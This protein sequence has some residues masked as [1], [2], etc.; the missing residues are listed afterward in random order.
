MQGGGRGAA[1]KRVTNE[2]RREWTGSNIRKAASQIQ[3][4][5]GWEK[6]LQYHLGNDALGSYAREKG[7]GL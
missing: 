1:C 6:T 3:K 7:L 4:K 5:S 2:W